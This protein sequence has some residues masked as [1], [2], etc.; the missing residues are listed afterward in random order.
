[1]C[2]INFG[3]YVISKKY[4]SSQISKVSHPSPVTDVR[5]EDSDT[6]KIFCIVLKLYDLKYDL[7]SNKKMEKF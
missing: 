3:K 4:G 5:C 7:R 6:K 1:M 2:R